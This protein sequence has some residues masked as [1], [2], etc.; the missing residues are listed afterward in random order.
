MIMLR[1]NFRKYAFFVVTWKIIVVIV[2]QFSW[3]Q[4]FLCCYICHYSTQGLALK[5]LSCSSRFI[6]LMS[7]A[8]QGRNPRVLNLTVHNGITIRCQRE[9]A[10]H[11]QPMDIEIVGKMYNKLYSYYCSQMCLSYFSFSCCAWT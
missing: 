10:I 4:I 9:L 7:N 11:C 1:L 2:S 6:G 3:H 5:K 8:Y